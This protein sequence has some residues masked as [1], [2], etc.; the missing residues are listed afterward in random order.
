MKLSEVKE[1]ALFKI[2]NREYIKI[3]DNDKGTVVVMRDCVFNSTYG[4]NN[5]FAESKILKRLNEEVLPE[6]ENDIGV[7]NLLEFETDLTS[8]DGLKTYGSITSK[9]SIPTFDLYRSNVEIF[10]KFKLDR[11]WWLAT[12]DTTSEH[13]NDWWC[14]CVSPSG[15]IGGHYY[16]HLGVRPVLL[17]VSSIS[18]SCE[19]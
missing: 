1:K 12:P 8:L 17:F 16:F 9:I 10:D 13:V 4:E 19:E 3:C 14:S 6:I 11:Y 15:I 7:E 5:N 18:V 2:G